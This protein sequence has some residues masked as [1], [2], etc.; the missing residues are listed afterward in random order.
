MN[1]LNDMRGVLFVLSMLMLVGCSSSEHDFVE[2]EGVVKL[3]GQTVPGV[4]I[5]FR[6]LSGTVKSSIAV[7]DENGAFRALCTM[8]QAGVLR[9][10]NDVTFSF[11]RDADMWYEGT[12][13]AS[14]ELAKK[15]H[16]H[17]QENGPIRLDITQADKDYQLEVELP[18]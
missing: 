1:G 7:T 9:G 3:N 6:P 12:S 2:L 10:E 14:P 15:L 4:S 11:D 16:K 5:D 13:S 18:E 17:C 8:S